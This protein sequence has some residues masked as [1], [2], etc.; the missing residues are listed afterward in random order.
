MKCVLRASGQL[1]RGFEVMALG[2]MCIEGMAA[3][4]KGV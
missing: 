1:K 3:V 4:E 2:E